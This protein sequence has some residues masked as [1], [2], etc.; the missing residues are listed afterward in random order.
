MI[1]GLALP[2]LNPRRPY[3]I[4]GGL[5]GSARSASNAKNYGI[6]IPAAAGLAVPGALILLVVAAH[7][8]G[9]YDL[10]AKTTATIGGKAA[11]RRIHRSQKIADS[12]RAVAIYQVDAGATGTLSSTMSFGFDFETDHAPVGGDGNEAQGAAAALYRFTGLS[13]LSPVSSH[14][15]RADGD[16]SIPVPGEGYLVVGGAE[17]TS[18]G[19]ALAGGS[20]FTLDVSIETD[21]DGL[22]AAHVDDPRTSSVVFRINT[23]GVVAALVYR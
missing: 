12:G 3:L 9:N 16:L 10:T 22:L 1:P 18:P 6:S 21:N 15:R 8:S 20:P 11:T 7:R 13:S 19:P 14:N 23:D 5:V 2:A 17:S 4:Q